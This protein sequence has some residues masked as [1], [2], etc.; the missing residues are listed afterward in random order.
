VERYEQLRGRAL[1]G[2][3]GGWRLGLAVLQHRGVSAWLRTCRAVPAGLG[4][5]APAR[6]AAPLPVGQGDALVA[7]LASMALACTAGR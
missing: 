7:A 2:E 5:A 3:V 6:P 4:V 1:D